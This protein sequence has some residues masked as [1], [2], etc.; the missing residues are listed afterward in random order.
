MKQ[1]HKTSIIVTKLMGTSYQAECSCGWLA[2]KSHPARYPA[3]QDAE[4]HRLSK[5]S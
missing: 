4:N 3:K 5:E 2:P 1:E